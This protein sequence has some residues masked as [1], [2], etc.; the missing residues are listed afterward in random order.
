MLYHCD[1][2]QDEILADTAALALNKCVM[3]IPDKLIQ[4]FTA[5]RDILIIIR[6][7]YNTYDSL[8]R[9]ENQLLLSLVAPTF[10]SDIAEILNR[11]WNLLVGKIMD[12]AETTV[13]NEK[14][15]NL[16]IR[17]INAQLKDVG[18]LSDE[19]YSVSSSI[20]NYGESLKPARDKLLALFD[21]DIA[22]SG[23]ELGGTSK[24]DFD[25]FL[26]NI[27][28]YSDLVGT[29]IGVGPLDFSCSSCSGDVYD[30]LKYLRK[31]EAGLIEQTAIK[32]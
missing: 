5:L 29:Q 23:K 15:E 11:D 31:G 22:L 2:N 26:E 19:I 28:I 4:D 8:Y 9:D 20:L 32:K 1:C 17:L 7:D 27:Q 14:R 12:P 16:T 3:S 13:K 6:R 21:R 24:E 25:S 30:L 18:L 10:F